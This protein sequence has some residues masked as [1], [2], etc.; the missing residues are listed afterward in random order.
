MEG[1]KMNDKHAL[2]HMV[3]TQKHNFV[4]NPVHTVEVDLCKVKKN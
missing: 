2:L 4:P 3:E 1:E